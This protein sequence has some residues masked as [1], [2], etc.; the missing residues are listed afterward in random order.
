MLVILQRLAKE[1]GATHEDR[2]NIDAVVENLHEFGRAMNTNIE[3]SLLSP[4]MDNE[5]APV[6]PKRYALN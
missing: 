3:R 1:T 2:A 6:K 4:H 5:D